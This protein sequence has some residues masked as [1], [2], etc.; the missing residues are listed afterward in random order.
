ML[1]LSR[2]NIQGS[3]AT[4]MLLL[5]ICPFCHHSFIYHPLSINLKY[6]KFA[7]VQ[8]QALLLMPSIVAFLEHLTL[9]IYV[10]ILYFGLCK[11][12]E[13]CLHGIGSLFLFGEIQ[14]QSKHHEL[15]SLPP[16]SLKAA[17]NPLTMTVL[18]LRFLQA[19]VDN[20]QPRSSQVGLGGIWWA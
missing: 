7:K 9:F 11:I 13:R 19:M 5:M 17:H 6:P 1:E 12:L 3:S 18:L 20:H 14:Q 8:C 10:T 15:P 16:T 4:K 2:V